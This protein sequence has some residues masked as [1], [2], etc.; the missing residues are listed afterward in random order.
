MQKAKA[1]DSFSLLALSRQEFW[2]KDKKGKKTE[3][4]GGQSEPSSS[5]SKRRKKK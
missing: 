4:K 3:A 1:K 2:K 5:S